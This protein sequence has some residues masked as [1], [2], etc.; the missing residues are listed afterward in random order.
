M[1]DL[2]SLFVLSTMILGSQEAS[3]QNDPSGQIGI[4]V[5]KERCFGPAANFSTFSQYLSDTGNL[6]EGGLRPS[7]EPA[8]A[9]NKTW[10]HALLERRGDFE[11]VVTVYGNRWA[12]QIRCE[13][14]GVWENERDFLETFEN[15][16]INGQRLG[17]T[18]GFGMNR[19]SSQAEL[20]WAGRVWSEYRLIAL[21]P[22]EP[23]PSVEQHDIQIIRFFNAPDKERRD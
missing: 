18:G 4:G 16:E 5:F 15:V 20:D 19:P 6:V 2:L 14:R 8:F 22:V 1:R 21:F 3:A 12:P 9:A 11:I 7:L 23:P 10:G 13:L 17:S